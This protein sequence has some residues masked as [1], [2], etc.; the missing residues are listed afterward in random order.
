MNVKNETDFDY[1][2][3]ISII[4]NTPNYL[5]KKFRAVDSIRTFSGKYSAELIFRQAEGLARKISNSF[6]DLVEL[7]VLLVSLSY[8]PFNEIDN[9]FNTAEF[10]NIKWWRELKFLILQNSSHDVQIS[11]SAVRKVKIKQEAL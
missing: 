10:K 1:L 2:M 3:Q 7:F 5:F 8:K 4:A 11:L 6:E 9:L